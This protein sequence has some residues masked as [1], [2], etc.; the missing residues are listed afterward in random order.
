MPYKLRAQLK[1]R[2]F[3][4]QKN[5]TVPEGYASDGA[6]G[7]IDIFSDAWWVHDWLCETGQFDDGTP[8]TNWQ[9]ST[10]LS[11]ILRREER[12]LRAIYWWPATWLFGGG[13]ARNNGMW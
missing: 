11:D 7:A 9:A 10:V 8:C 4:Y 3:R 13:K 12:W 1:Y 6:T 2:S 5:I